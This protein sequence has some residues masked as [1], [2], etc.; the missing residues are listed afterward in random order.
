MSNLKVNSFADDDPRSEVC[1]R[2]PIKYDYVGPSGS[3]APDFY[4]LG[5][6]PGRTEAEEHCPF[7]GD[8][9]KLLRS[10]IDKVGLQWSKIRLSNSVQCRPVDHAGH[11]RTPDPSEV[12]NCFRFFSRSDILKHRPKIIVAVGK[13]AL[14]AL[15]PDCDLPISEARQLDDL[16]YE[17]IPVRTIYHP[18]YLL[19]SGGEYSPAY[20]TTLLDLRGIKQ[21]VEKTDLSYSEN[22]TQ[23]FTIFPHEFQEYQHYIDDPV[24]YLDYESTYSSP[25][26]KDFELAMIG[27]CGERASICIR[28]QDEGVT[29]EF[30]DADRATIAHFLLSRKVRVFNAAFEIPVTLRCLGVDISDCIDIDVMQGLKAL[31]ITG[32]LKIICSQVL[33]AQRWD[34][35]VSQW[36]EASSSLAESIVKLSRKC[37]IPLSILQKSASFTEFLNSLHLSITNLERS[38]NDTKKIAVLRKLD[39]QLEILNQVTV[40][41]SKFWEIITQSLGSERAAEYSTHVVPFLN[42]MIET[43]NFV[44]HYTWLPVE[45]LAK[46]NH[47]D[48]RYTRDLDKFLQ[49]S[50]DEHGCSAAAEIY[51]DHM[52]LAFEIESAGIVWDDQKAKELDEKYTRDATE[53]LRKFLSHP[54]V[55]RV[56]ELTNQD[57]LQIQI[58]DENGLRK[59]F[60]PMSTSAENRLKLSAILVSFEIQVAKIIY[61]LLRDNTREST[62]PFLS[63]FV[64]S[65]SND[66]ENQKIQ[67]QLYRFLLNMIRSQ[68]GSHKLNEASRRL[69]ARASQWTLP[70]S[71]SSTVEVL[72]TCQTKIMG[73][74]PDNESTWTDEFRLLYYY[75]LYKKLTK[76]RSAYIHGKMGRGMVYVV[77]RRDLETSVIPLR[78]RQ[79]EEKISSQEA[80]LLQPKY[81]VCDAVTKRWKSYVHTI[82]WK[83]ELRDIHIS[84]YTNGILVHYDSSQSEIKVL[85][86]FSNDH[87]LLEALKAKKDIHRY[88]ASAIWNKPEEEITEAERR[89]SKMGTFSIIYGKSEEGFAEDFMGGSVDK[90]REMF[91]K[92]F[93][94]FP[95]VKKFID[96]KHR[97]FRQTGQVRTIF[98]DSLIIQAD[99]NNPSSVSAGLRAA[100][101]WPIQHASSCIV[102]L[103]IYMVQKALRREGVRAATFGFTHDSGD[104]DVHPSGLVK[105]LRILPILAEKYPSERFGVPVSIDIAI[106]VRGN[107]QIEIK[108]VKTYDGD[109]G[110][111]A[112]FEGEDSSL[113]MLIKTLEAERWKVDVDIQDTVDRYTEMKE[114]FIT[115]RAYTHYIGKHQKIRKGYMRVLPKL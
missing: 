17:G 48:T 88:I 34:K 9:G 24:V 31:N 29:H 113:E 41:A 36:V 80:Y 11:N 26:D 87:K 100:Q 65:S 101:N 16:V 75:R 108:N 8:S 105:V 63:L 83:C 54:K 60:N 45:V 28:I 112:K 71:S 33:G 76:S 66:S 84:R 21:L 62:Y 20:S 64:A 15:F 58:S 53:T 1:N 23:K 104:I 98:G 111:E 56:L 61:D 39:T 107:S 78:L 50:L 38:K 74:D 40:L 77:N 85:A 79:W 47:N 4:L 13:V 43:R 95:G 91:H 57:L 82:P 109:T 2:C 92:I 32:G 52:K 22:H 19:R 115:R 99:F 94:E 86:R 90:A 14:N 49:R 27:I 12:S 37:D 10:M 3:Y 7:V 110:F 102:G 69:L 114:L 6:A 103:S 46:Y 93:T 73:I 59:L 97:E 5:E 18:S 55:I 42:R 96:E 25:Y 44:Y 30:S 106:G 81:E 51:T 70:D 67:P 68:Q 35:E 72:Y 89:F